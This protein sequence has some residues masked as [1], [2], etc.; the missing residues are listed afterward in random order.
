GTF[1][2]D[3]FSYY[4]APGTIKA[5]STVELAVYGEGDVLLS[6]ENFSVTVTI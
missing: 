3:T 1:K 2:E 6:Q 5:N 4:V